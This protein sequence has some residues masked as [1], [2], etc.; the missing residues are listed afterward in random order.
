MMNKRLFIVFILGFSS[1]LP[2]ALISS[3]LQAWFAYS[4][5]SVFVTGTLSLI[6]LP[7]AYRIFWGPILDRYSLFNLGKRRSWIFAMQCLL[8]FG[9]NLMAWFIPEQHP[10]LIALLALAL[11]CFSATQDIAID[12]HR[13]EYLP[14]TSML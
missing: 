8:L 11:A 1:G 13:A 5:M 9:F 12:A 4:G 10:K 2:M 7:Y 6:S 14:M 3:T